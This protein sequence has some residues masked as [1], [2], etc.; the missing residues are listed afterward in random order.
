MFPIY[1]CWDKHVTEIE[2]N[3]IM[4]AIEEVESIFGCRVYCYGNTTWLEGKYR[5]ADEIMATI[6]RRSNGRV[7]GTRTMDL[8]VE[9][10][11]TWTE[12]GV[13]ILF[14]GEELTM[15]EL[16]WC[17][18]CARTG[19]KVAVESTAW[20]RSLPEWQR[21]AC[22]AHT[23]RHELG[24]TFRC[25]ANLKR[26][27]TVDR[28]GPHCTNK[29]CTMRQTGTMDELLAAIDEEDPRH[30]F[31]DQCMDDMRAFK[32]AQETPSPIRPYGRRGA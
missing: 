11:K 20:Y 18:G 16:N 5:S 22:I 19:K 7:D 29:G 13:F 14:T 32:K 4:G 1:I 3:A 30:Y 8:M 17:F 2:K 23:L 28:L 21:R 6:P 15:G 12:P 10:T 27:N 9:I 31:C 25:A 26:S 24:H